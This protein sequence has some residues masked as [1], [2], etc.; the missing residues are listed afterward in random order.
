MVVINKKRFHDGY[1][2]FEKGTLWEV[3]SSTVEGV[4]L[5]NLGINYTLRISQ[6]VFKGNFK[7]V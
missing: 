4:V 2:A 1:Y 3:V 6:T 7:E 5:V